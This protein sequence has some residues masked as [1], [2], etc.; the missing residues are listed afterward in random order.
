MCH[1]ISQTDVKNKC[2]LFRPWEFSYIRSWI[3]I[4]KLDF[5]FCVAR[6]EYLLGYP[7]YIIELLKPVKNTSRMWKQDSTWLFG[8]LY[9][10]YFSQ[11]HSNFYDDSKNQYNLYGWLDGWSMRDQSAPIC[12][13]LHFHSI[14]PLP[15]STCV[16]QPVG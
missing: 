4:Y 10:K 14:L 15:M 6:N 2:I 5:K 12:Q 9:S 8:E 16:V 1:N 13:K 7:N 11:Y 3:M